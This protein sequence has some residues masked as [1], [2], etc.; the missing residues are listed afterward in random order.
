MVPFTD[1][2]YLGHPIS[3]YLPATLRRLVTSGPTYDIDNWR[4]RISLLDHFIPM[5]NCS[6]GP[7]LDTVRDASNA[8]LHSWETEGMDWDGW[9]GEV[10][11]ARAEFA[12]LIHADPN[13]VAVLSSVSQATA[14][15]AGALDYGARSEVL[16]SRAEF[17][18]V[19]QVWLA[20]EQVGARVNWVD[21]HDGVVPIDGYRAAI[22][23]NTLLLSACHGYYQTGFKQDLDALVDI[24]HGVGALL[25]VDAYQTAGT[26]PIDVQRTAVD[27]LTAGNLK[28]LMGAPGIAFL[29]VRP[30]VSE[31]L[32]PTMT[33]WFGQQEPFAFK[34]DQLEYADGARRLDS[35]TP[36]IWNAYVARAG[37]AAIR[38]V[39][40][41][42]ILNWTEHLSALLIEGGDRRGLRRLGP[43][44]P[45]LKTP[46][47]AFLCPG[48]THV[49]EAMLRE[50][51][52]I[53]SARGPVIR[54]APHFYS[55]AEDVEAALDALAEVYAK[56]S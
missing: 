15:V 6:R 53:G 14:A 2:R 34:V 52:V 50:R 20:H 36:P 8:Y 3:P 21:V 25:F 31:R 1:T 19:G 45:S 42:A 46:S 4:S 48:D 56:L 11:G 30:E 43:S 47:T 18:T 38:E 39:G 28:Y 37:M 49:A 7:L 23:S 10:E 26:H 40:V 16:A 17:P 44:D 55:T 27:F 41:E 22:S 32:R 29:Y 24:A 9:M 35:G 33:G 54:Y 12:A 51:G 5:N 13:D